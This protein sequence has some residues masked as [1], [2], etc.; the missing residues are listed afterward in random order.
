MSTVRIKFEASLEKAKP[1]SLEGDSE[2]E[3]NLVM[4]AAGKEE[5][6]AA[7]I[8][9][10]AVKTSNNEGPEAGA[11]S[12]W[13]SSELP[14]LRKSGGGQQ[15]GGTVASGVS[16]ARVGV[17]MLQLDGL[18]RTGTIGLALLLAVGFGRSSPQV[19]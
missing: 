6:L 8:Q 15:G 9:K 7:A 3:T 14:P 17:P 11:V 2:V 4:S 18:Q 10:G 13:Q 16:T 19:R 1:F 12:S 5:R